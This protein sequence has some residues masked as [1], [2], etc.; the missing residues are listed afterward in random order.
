MISLL[1]HNSHTVVSAYNHGIAD[2]SGAHLAILTLSILST[3]FATDVSD[4]I[5]MLINLKWVD[6]VTLRLCFAVGNHGL[7]AAITTLMVGD[8]FY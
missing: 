6:N 8:N 4:Y 5:L 2:M 1:F 7:C 3:V